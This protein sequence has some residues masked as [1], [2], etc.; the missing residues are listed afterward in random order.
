[1]THARARALKKGRGHYHRATRKTRPRARRKHFC[2][3]EKARGRRANG[4][5]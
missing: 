4:H 3:R 2:P 1:M 5:S